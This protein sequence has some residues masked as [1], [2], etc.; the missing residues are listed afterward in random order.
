VQRFR[1][2]PERGHAVSAYDSRGVRAAPVQHDPALLV[3]T[4]LDIG[5]NGEIGAHEAPVDQLFLVV[6]G[7]GWVAGPDGRSAAI[8]AGEAAFW[9]AG[10]RHGAGSPSGMRALVLEGDGLDPDA[11]LEALADA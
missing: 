8:H 7:E 5:P 2:D 3:V 4:A 9:R 10:E 6:G 11:R 1:F